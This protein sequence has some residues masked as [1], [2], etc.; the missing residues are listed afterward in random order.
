MRLV[1]GIVSA[2]SHPDVQV[3][4]VTGHV[5]FDTV[6]HRRV[7]AVTSVVREQR[8]ATPDDLRAYLAVLDDVMATTTVLPMR[9]GVMFESAEAVVEELLEPN[10]PTFQELLA[11]MRGLAEMRVRAVY[12]VDEALTSIMETRADLR[13]R[14]RLLDTLPE[15]ASYF[16]RI[17]L[18]RA[19][20]DAMSAMARRDGAL[21][22]GRLAELS[23]DMEPGDQPEGQ[24]V[25]TASYLVDGRGVQALRREVDTIR[26]QFGDLLDIR[27]IGPMPPFS[28]V[29]LEIQP[30]HVGSGV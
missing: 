14:R 8:E 21:I 16:D 3:S 20:A 4:G 17:E 2:R 9:F 23:V 25:S 19:L 7:A 29:D 28:F 1:Y 5:A 18:G 15:D 22:E 30:A 12:R 13:R 11:R 10:A 27:A 26:D 6:A 24:R